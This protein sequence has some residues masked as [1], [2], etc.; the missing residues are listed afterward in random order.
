MMHGTYNIKK[1][2]SLV[3]ITLSQICICVVNDDDDDDDDDDMNWR[4][5]AHA[6]SASACSST[7]LFYKLH[8]ITSHSIVRLFYIH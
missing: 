1:N 5:T 8:M 4:L 7:V 6:I 2:T 3:R